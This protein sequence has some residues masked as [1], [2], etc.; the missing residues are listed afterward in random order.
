[1]FY[2]L[3]AI[4]AEVIGTLSMK[5]ATITGAMSGH[6]VMYI[7]ITLS[8][9]TLSMAIKKIPLGVAYA[10]WEGL[11]VLAITGFSVMWFDESMSL[12]KGLGIVTLLLGIWLIKS[13]TY[14]SH[15]KRRLAKSPLALDVRREHATA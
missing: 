3:M 14:K 7:M 4:I 12:L 1:M 5:Y 15:P 6:I 9:I 8:Y 10:L 2:L 11:G 13:G